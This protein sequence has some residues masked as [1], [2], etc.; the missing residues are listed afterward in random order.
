[1][2]TIV[3]KNKNFTVIGKFHFKCD[4]IDGIVSN[5]VRQPIFC[6][7]VL[8]KL[9]GYKVFFRPETIQYKNKE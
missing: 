1:M 4:V 3:K 5:G 7:F 2:S 9:S 8:E 6:D